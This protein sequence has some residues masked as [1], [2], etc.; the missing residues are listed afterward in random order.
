MFP[1]WEHL[2]E[3]QMARARLGGVESLIYGVL[4]RQQKKLDR[5]EGRKTKNLTLW[6]I[7]LLFSS[8]L[9]TFCSPKM[10]PIGNNIVTRYGALLEI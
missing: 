4:T 8:I 10:F 5:H 1:K 9:K 3:F 2:I 6:R 7:N